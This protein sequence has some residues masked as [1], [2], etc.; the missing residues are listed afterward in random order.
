MPRGKK[1]IVFVA[2]LFVLSSLV[3]A[4]GLNLN[5]FGS[6][7]V[8]MGGAFVGLADDYSAIFWNP[9]GIA[10]FGE[11]TLGMTGDLIMPS[12]TYKFQFMGVTLVNAESESKI[13]PS[14][15]AGYYHPLSDKLVAGI[16]VYTPSGLGISW[17]GADFA[18]FTRG[19]SYKWET[20]IGVIS[21][22]PALAYKISDQ[23][24]VGATLNLNYG[25]FNIDQ[26]AGIATVPINQPPYS[27]TVDLGQY[28]ESS[29]GW[30][31]SGTLGIL[32][33]PSDIFSF[34]AT[35]RTPSKVTMSGEA[36]I[37]NFQ[38]LNI[39][40]ESEFEELKQQIIT[41]LSHELRTPLTSVY[42]YT[43]LALE[44]ATDLP[45]GDFQNFLKGIKKGTDRLTQLVEDLL[46]V[47]RLDTGELEQEF[48]L[49][50]SV[51]NDIDAI[52]LGSGYK[53]TM[54]G[55]LGSTASKVIRTSD[56]PVISVRKGEV[57]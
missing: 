47:V 28:S 37:S 4:N 18:P 41:L 6:R 29:D 14:G 13:Y 16:G 49:L 24:S 51:Q 22:S 8:A 39:A 40:T 44:E 26:H 48:E 20:Y 45:P 31:V 27:T 15:L 52:V 5:G 17:D 25:F 38:F 53:G 7:A 9:A 11:K 57:G 36:S 10:Q 3:S 1:T 50:G 46:M 35:V 34:G 2:F 43:E 32:V 21:I 19:Q 55:L 54:G 56:V 33:K 23:I 30:G 42:G 12:S